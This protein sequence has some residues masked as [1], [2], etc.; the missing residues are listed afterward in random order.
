MEALGSIAQKNKKL[1]PILVAA[2]AD[3]SS[4]V[5]SAAVRAIASLGPEAVPALLEVLKGKKSPV[6]VIRAAEAIG[7]IGPQAKTAVPLLVQM[8]KSSDWGMR[9]S[10]ITALGAIGPDAKAALPAIVQAYGNYLETGPKNILENLTAYGLGSLRG[11]G[12]GFSG[13]FT[14]LIYHET[15]K[16]DPSLPEAVGE[17]FKG[18]AKLFNG[19]GVDFN[20]TSG[21]DWPR[22]YTIL[23]K[24]FP[25]GANGS[26]PG[27]QGGIHAENP[28][29][30]GKPAI[31]WLRQ[32][33]EG[34][35]NHIAE[36]VAALGFIAQMH[37]E[38]IP[39]LAASLSSPIDEVA[40]T[41]SLALTDLGSQAMPAL[42]AVLDEA[43]KCR[44]RRTFY[45]AA[46]VSAA[47]QPEAKQLLAT[48]VSGLKENDWG[49]DWSLA[50]SSLYALGRIGFAA[51]TA[52]PAMIDAF[53]DCLKHLEREAK[54]GKKS[55]ASSMAR[56][57]IPEA[58]CVLWKK[59]I[60]T[61]G[62]YCRNRSMRTEYSA[63]VPS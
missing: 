6:L 58:L 36:A 57:W 5:G 56:I 61:F 50:R 60:L 55:S 27:G 37:E 53:G 9:A 3:K 54:K 17:L 46:I 52:L 47:I 8:L 13:D 14:Q 63:K 40:T 15:S 29:Y 43:L 10:A 20:P 25:A 21:T 41:A 31:F 51:K 62:T 59:L 28:T 12:S 24:R 16:I 1:I 23:K 4:S 49:K 22:F 34:D 45:H 30:L 35:A 26:L 11:K 33:K 32:R 7:R 44:S 18:A 42:T 19:A 48:L 39:V 38:F 2:L